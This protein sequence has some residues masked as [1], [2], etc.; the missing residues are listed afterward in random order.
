MIVFLWLGSIIVTPIIAQ[1]KG[2]NVGTF[3]LFSIFFGPIA[4]VATLLI[5]Q[6]SKQIPRANDSSA[7]GAA[8]ELVSIKSLLASLE[9]RVIALEARLHVSLP[10][11]MAQPQAPAVELP[12]TEP[13]TSEEFEFVFGKY[14]LNR[15]GVV[16]FVLGVAFFIGYTFRYLNA[17]SKIGVG[18]GLAAGFFLWGKY[19]EKKNKYVRLSWG[20]SGGAWN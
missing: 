20:I 11:E 12:T 3:L 5:P 7:R 19:L 6:N 16:I 8:E 9:K 1:H 15:I 10:E 18:Y 17:I 13:K 14:W 2:W 4:L